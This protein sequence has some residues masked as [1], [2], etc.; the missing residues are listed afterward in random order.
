MALTLEQAR[1]YRQRRYRT[2]DQAWV[3][4]REQR[5]LAHLLRAWLPPQGPWLDVPCGY[6]RFAPLLARL[7]FTAVGAD[8]SLAM[9]RLAAEAH[10]RGRWVQASLLALPFADGAFDGALC[11]RLLHHRRPDAERQ[12]ILQELARVTRRVV[13]VSFYRYTPLHAATRRWRGGRARQGMLTLARF[14][15][16]VAASGLELASL[17]ALLRFVHAQTFAVLRKA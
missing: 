16:L 10:G 12:Q 15:A 7:G 2:L 5:L 3:N 9:L 8:L 1:A 6:G 14:R 17:H 11:V 4:W 13:L